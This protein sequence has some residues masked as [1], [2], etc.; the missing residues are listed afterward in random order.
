M[1]IAGRKMIEEAL[2]ESRPRLNA[3]SENSP[4]AAYLRNLH[5]DRYEHIS[6]EI[7][8]LIGYTPDEMSA[9]SFDDLFQ[10]VHPDDRQG[11][12]QKIERVL[13]NGRGMLE[14]RFRT[15]NGDYRWLADSISVFAR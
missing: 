11:T 2:F 12:A 1:D 14:Y 9:M 10:H 8:K 15:K 7:E 4:D 3:V 5:S 13:R 6:P